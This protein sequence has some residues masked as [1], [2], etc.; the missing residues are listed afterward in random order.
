[1]PSGTPSTPEQIEA[2]ALRLRQAQATGSPIAPLREEIPD[3]D[4][5]YAVQRANVRF[6][7]QQQG[8]RIVGRKIGLT[9]LAVQKQLGVDQPDFGTLFADMVYGDDEA[10]PARAVLQPKV[11]A[12]IALVLDRDI[13]HADATLVDVI[14]ATAYVLPAIEIVGSRIADWNI[15]FVDTVADNASSGAVVLGAVPIRLQGLD[16]KLC[17]M[18]MQR[19]DEVVS[20]GSG[21]A[22]L[23]H[24]LNAAV[25]L[26]RKMAALGEPL[27]AGDLVMT[28][29]LGP[30]V[31]ARAGDAF[32]ASISGIGSVRARFAA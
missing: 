14:A 7:Q 17:T 22:C 30:M 8:Q 25:W 18:R 10:V 13:V 4:A 21:A 3:G 28:G 12:E 9:S 19:G 6:A 27:R 20:E 5:A 32:E 23:G 31:P 11:E 1:M 2:W 15:R 24:P 26:A 29:A 16:L